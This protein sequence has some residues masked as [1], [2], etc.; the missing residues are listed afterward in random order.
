MAMAFSY[1]SSATRTPSNGISAGVGSNGGINGNVSG[2]ARRKNVMTTP[3][4]GLRGGVGSPAAMT[5][6]PVSRPMARQLKRV[7]SADDDDENVSLTEEQRHEVREA[8]DLFDSN[9]D[10][11]L[12]FHELK[13]SLQLLF[14]AD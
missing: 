8:F 13:V 5:N 11:F 4:P 6:V 9:R 7:E 3:S 12:D 14:I 10:G 1:G 2:S